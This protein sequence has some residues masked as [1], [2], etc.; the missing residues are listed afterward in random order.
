MI[1]IS[2]KSIVCPS[3]TLFEKGTHVK[4]AGSVLYVHKCAK[5]VAT[6]TKIPFCTEEV[7]VLVEGQ[8][9]SC[10]RYMEPIR[11]ILYHNY[12]ISACNPLYA[13][14]VKL[15]DGSLQQYGETLKKFNREIYQ[16]L[17][18]NNLN[19]SD[20]NLHRSLFSISDVKQ[21]QIPRTIRH[22]SKRIISREAFRDSDGK[23]SHEN[24]IHWNAQF[25]KQFFL[26]NEITIFRKLKT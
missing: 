15:E 24:F 7:S 8:N 11:K 14:V 18:N 20:E 2:K 23:Y 21:S 1:E 9:F 12:T 3:V 10:I 5:M 16:W 22:N 17:M 6:K 19:V 25:Q 26:K 4:R 13:D